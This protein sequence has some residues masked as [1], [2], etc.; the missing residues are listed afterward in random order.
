MSPF[1]TCAA[2]AKFPLQNLKSSFILIPGRAVDE[3][4]NTWAPVYAD[5][6]SVPHIGRYS[7]TKDELPFWSQEG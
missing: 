4:L 5:V 7:E 2:K 6:V 1:K 3:M